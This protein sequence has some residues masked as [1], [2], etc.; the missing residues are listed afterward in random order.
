MNIQDHFAKATGALEGNIRQENAK[1]DVRVQRSLSEDSELNGSSIGGGRMIKGAAN[2]ILAAGGTHSEQEKE[3][4]KK[5][6]AALK[7][8]GKIFQDHMDAM[9]AQAAYH[10]EKADE[11]RSKA[12]EIRDSQ[13]YKDAIQDVENLTNAFESGDPDRMKA[14]LEKRGIDTTGMPKEDIERAAREEMIKAMLILDAYDKEIADWMSIADEHDKAKKVI[15]AEA[16]D[17]AEK[18]KAGLGE[19]EAVVISKE[20]LAAAGVAMKISKDA[21]N[22]KE[23]H[24]LDAQR[25]AEKDMDDKRVEVA[26]VDQVDTQLN[27]FGGSPS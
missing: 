2:A 7:A 10:Q 17:I 16:K 3:R 24:D 23:G 15:E 13:E 4:K 27:A 21:G 11:A 18:V 9:A 22:S 26:E 5:M 19:E 1:D 12:T 8:S 6:S 20:N 25:E 14:E